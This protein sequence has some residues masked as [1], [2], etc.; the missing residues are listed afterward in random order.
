MH[1]LHEIRRALAQ[2]ACQITSI[3]FWY[4]P[5]PF[6]R[7]VF[8]TFALEANSSSHFR[9][10]FRFRIA[11][12]SNLDTNSN[13]NSSSSWNRTRMRARAIVSVEKCAR[14]A[15]SLGAIRHVDSHPFSNRGSPFFEAIFGTVFSWKMVPYGASDAVKNVTKSDKKRTWNEVN[16]T[17]WNV[18]NL[19]I[20]LDLQETRFRIE[21]LSKIIKTRGADKYKK[22]SKH[23][24]EMKPK[25][26]KHRSRNPIKNDA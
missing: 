1:S 13:H 20:T 23:G 9:A 21:G 11:I 25:S 10:I 8:E 22:I 18:L 12:N 3:E 4:Q 14:E 16:K 17:C 5:F 26:M 24:V 7:I 6:F 15:P 2:S 19:I